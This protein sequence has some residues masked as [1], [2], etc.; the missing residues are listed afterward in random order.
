MSVT[1]QPSPQT[2][3]TAAPVLPAVVQNLCKPSAP[4]IG[5][6]V[7]SERCT[8]GGTKAAGIVRH[9]SIDVS[10]T[11]IAG[12]FRP[13]QSFGVIPPG[14]DANGK[15]HKVRL[16]SIASPST[17]EDGQGNVLATTV[18]RTIDEHWDTHTLFLGV[19]SNHLCDLQPGDTVRITG[20]VGKRFLLPDQQ[21]EH[22]YIFFA[23]GTGIAPFRGMILELLQATHEGRTPNIVLVMGTPYDTDLLYDDDLVKLAQ[24]HPSFTYLPAISRESGV[25]KLYVQDRLRTHADLFEPMLND[26]RTLIYV[27]GIAG[28]ELGICQHLARTL[29]TDRLD[30]FLTTTDEAPS[31]PDD[32]TRQMIPRQV[33]P[34]HRMAI[35]VY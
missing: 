6:V 26:D 7:A 35:E 12:A 9:V 15:P 18:K 2:R 32:W 27:C 3:Q 23:T 4:G 17:G 33:R 20:P 13:G 34:T 24:D 25:E 21:N 19:A 31:N 11:P 14:T 16:Y 30:G 10:N 5:T 1:D 8:K 28:M 29:D 22:D